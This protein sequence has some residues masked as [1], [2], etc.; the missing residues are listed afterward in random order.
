MRWAQQQ[1]LMFIADRLKSSGFVNRQDLVDHF[2]ISIPTASADLKS[3]LKARPRAMR[4][5]P[6]SKRYERLARKNVSDEP[7]WY[8]ADDIDPR[9]ERDETL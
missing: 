8:E 1:R 5:N 2:R 4:Y 7:L 6:S 9:F 3:F